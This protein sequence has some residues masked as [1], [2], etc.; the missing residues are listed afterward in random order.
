MTTKHLNVVLC[1][2]LVA[3]AETVG[4]A[5]AKSVVCMFLLDKASI[6]LVIAHTSAKLSVQLAALTAAVTA[7][8]G[9][10]PEGEGDEYNREDKNKEE[11]FAS[12][13]TGGSASL[14]SCFTQTSLMTY[15]RLLV[16]QRPADIYPFLLSTATRQI[17]LDE[18]VCL[19]LCRDMEVVDATALLL[20]RRGQ[21]RSACALLLGQISTIL[22]E[23]K[24]EI[25]R[26]ESLLAV[27]KGL[28]VSLDGSLTHGE[29]MAALKAL[30]AQ[31]ALAHIVDCTI[32]LCLRLGMQPQGVE[33]QAKHAMWFTISD[34]LLR[35]RQ[36]L[37]SPTSY[38]TTSELVGLMVVTQLKKVLEQMKAVVGTTEITRN[39]FGESTKG[40]TQLSDFKDVL[41]SMLSNAE[42]ERLLTSTINEA[43][44]RDLFNAKVRKICTS[45]CGVWHGS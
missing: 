7:C 22:S 39:I 11:T 41:F 42:E 20:E 45:R 35:E 5:C 17:C 28:L 3:I 19:Q 24:Q 12:T 37:R 6:S 33:E 26:N 8:L 31:V 36:A 32:G 23:A 2:F 34:H 40:G 10:G 30:P 9:E 1:E 27:A 29:A 21:A 18:A 44:R 15:F 14:T 43:S 16:S 38:S 4:P 13:N 25:E